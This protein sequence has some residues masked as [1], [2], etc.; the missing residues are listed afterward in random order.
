[1][2]TAALLTV[3]KARRKKKTI[4]GWMD[5]KSAIEQYNR[6]LLRLKRNNTHS[7]MDGTQ[8]HGERKKTDAKE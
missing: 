1:M 4:T 5:F 8:K 7:V 2:F 6:I 3:G